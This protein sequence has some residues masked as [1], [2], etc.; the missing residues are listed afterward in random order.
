M[1]G[2]AILSSL[3]AIGP[4][5]DTS[6]HTIRGRIVGFKGIPVRAK[7]RSTGAEYRTR[8]DEE[9][10]YELRLPAG[11]YE[12]NYDCLALEPQ[13]IRVTWIGNS[14]GYTTT[15]ID[16]YRGPKEPC[17]DAPSGSSDTP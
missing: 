10:E 15:H 17:K 9:G 6:T 8:T 7:N 14:I 4:L 11:F 16:G 5:L 13:N 2:V 12:I 3:N 1:I